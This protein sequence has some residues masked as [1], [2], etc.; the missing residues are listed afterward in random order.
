M[1]GRTDRNIRLS[2]YLDD[3]TGGLTLKQLKAEAAKLRNEIALLP[4]GTEEYVNKAKRLK[5]VQ[6][7]I[8]QI[9]KDMRVQQGLWGRLA[10]GA[11]KFQ[12]LAVGVIG[13]TAGL[14]LGFKN[15]IQK[16]AEL[17][18]SIADVQKTTG[19][20]KDEVV[21]MMKSFQSID[22]RSSRKELLELARIAGKLGI[23]GT[24]DIQQFVR[25]ADQ[26][27]VALSEDLGGDVEES[28]RQIGKLT[29]VFRL[30]TDRGMN[31]EESMLK[32]GSAINALGASSTANEEFLVEFGKRMGGIAPLAKISI[33]DTL[34][35][36]AALDQ[37]GQTAEVSSTA[38][39][40]LIPEMFKDTASFA[41]IAGMKTEDFANLLSTDAN[42][43]ILKF[44]EGLKGNNEGMSEL[45]NRL[46]G[47]GI[48]G[49]RAV[50]V[51]GVLANNIDVVREQQKLSNEEFEKGTSL[52][53]EFNTKNE[54][55]AA[56]LAKV[57]RAIYGAFI[58]SKFLN[59]IDRAV[60]RIADW[61][62]IPLS[63]TLEDQRTK[64]NE[65]GI[66][67]ADVNLSLEDRKKLLDQLKAINPD[68]VEGL[69]AEN[70][71]YEK[72][73]ANI[74][75]YNDEMINR[76]IVQKQQEEIEKAVEQRVRKGNE[77][78]IQKKR[79]IDAIADATDDLM[80]KDESYG[81]R[82]Q[83]IQ[84]DQNL[85]LIE[86]AN[87]IAE[88]G[89][90]FNEFDKKFLQRSVRTSFEYNIGV[91]QTAMDDVK[92]SNEEINDLTKERNELMKELNVTLSTTP[93]KPPAPVYKEGD[94]MIIDGI[95]MIYKGGKWVKKEG[96]PKPPVDPSTKTIDMMLDNYEELEAREKKQQ[97]LILKDI[98]DQV[99]AF[100]V[101]KDEEEKI[102]DQFLEESLKKQDQQNDEILNRIQK[103]QALAEE[104]QNIS[105]D[106]QM[107]YELMQLDELYTEEMRMTEEYQ[108]IKQGI[109]DKYAA[110][111]RQRIISQLQLTQQVLEQGNELF[112]QA[113]QF[114][115]NKAGENEEQIK[116]I[117]KRYADIE[118]A[119]QAAQIAANTALAIAQINANPAVNADLT[120]IL[121]GVL[122]GLVAANGAAQLVI[123]NQ[124]RKAVQGLFTGG[125]TGDGDPTQEAG[126]FP[127]GQPYHKQEYVIPSFVRDHPYVRSVE[128][129]LESIRQR[130]LHGYAEGGPVWDMVKK[131][132][133]IIR[134][135]AEEL[136]NSTEI[137]LL[138]LIYQEC[139][140]FKYVKAVIDQRGMID[141]QD[142]LNE[143]SETKDTA[144]F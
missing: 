76:I 113:K 112:A 104:Y 70:L 38:F 79:L 134:D 15:M 23:E 9:N 13:A 123:L 100:Q 69:E 35:L 73:A 34:G 95:L 19:M 7:G 140:R 88:L 4:R 135:K 81:K 132:P 91:Y 94:E 47:L 10:D 5:E 20:T 1:A 8:N 101:A 93:E 26:I 102:I 116:E 78:A 129:V 136:G 3:K 54:N 144:K 57:G 53:D 96:P 56:N 62:T 11:N 33:E 30:T 48:D 111:E 14:V 107:N 32:T 24:G 86:K 52:T 44:V 98:Q 130:K 49:A 41:E 65:L 59:I 36:G 55:L 84:S 89:K 39:M 77:A 141:I 139:R 74:Q 124:Q 37:L 12:A 67:I 110:I 68:I 63:K 119:I 106:Q 58:N 25:A 75:A 61:T 50:G 29:D 83:K 17:S 28:V 71:N 92:K 125:Y 127:N 2:V 122:T 99:K 46:D 128:P 97:E 64:V 143:N 109:L 105:V 16:N 120:Q 131:V 60:S 115:L 22:T 114:E 80:S 103:R 31:L 27:K 51:L 87:A 21:D 45:A 108:R 6:S 133:G 43:A 66:E 85:S 121:R 118:F 42:E 90:Q 126:V 117:N 82:A 138:R 40:K 137:E 142:G 72:L 18:D